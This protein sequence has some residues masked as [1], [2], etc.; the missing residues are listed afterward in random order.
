MAVTLFGD[1]AFVGKDGAWPTAPFS[2]GSATPFSADLDVTTAALSASAFATA[3]D[4]SL[5]LKLDQEGIRVSGLKAKLYGG[6]LSGEFDLSNNAGTGLFSGQM[7]LVDADLARALPGGGLTGKA[8]FSSELSAG[9]KSVDG[10]IA[11]LS[12]SG[13]ASLKGLTVAGVNP[14]AF[15]A[16]ISKADAIGRDIDAAKTAAFAPQIAA[17]GSFPAQDTEVAFTIANGVLRAPPVS[18]E[19]EAA[20]LSAAIAA[21]LGA[22]TVSVKGSV[23][24]KPGDEALVGSE[25]VMNFDV[26]G[27]LGATT[28][29]FDSQP[30]AQF[31]TQRALEKEQ[32]RVEAMQAALLE[33]QRQRR[34]VRYYAALQDARVKAEAERQRLEELRVKAEAEA[35]AKA[36]ADYQAQLA[37]EAQA[38][39]DEEARLAAEQAARTKAEE[40]TRAKA[41]AE[42]AKA[43]ADRIAAQAEAAKAVEQAKAEDERRKAEQAAKA[44]EQEKAA[45]QAERE[46]AKPAAPTIDRAPL[47]PVND[48]SAPARPAPKPDVFSIENLLKSLGGG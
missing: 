3:Y 24:Y 9:G 11:A 44:A 22:A 29:S 40:E 31:L 5:A 35:R 25:P 7:K 27:P 19:N 47:P 8:D 34:E 18:L 17:E 6:A 41:E 14:D 28:R 42:A 38:K 46:A 33:K 43:L 13:T 16:F 32:R 45:A 4:A 15:A 20:T 30:L 1:E 39:A 48:N 12:G 21:D 2:A 26:E 10:M 37:A 23:T 36:A